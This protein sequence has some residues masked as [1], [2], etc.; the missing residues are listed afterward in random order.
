MPKAQWTIQYQII[1]KCFLSATKK[2]FLFIFLLIFLL[3]QRTEV[4]KLYKN[5]RSFYHH[6][7][8][9]CI[10]NS[11][12]HIWFWVQQ[13]SSESKVKQLWYPAPCLFLPCYWPDHDMW[14]RHELWL[15]VSQCS[16]RPNPLKRSL[17]GM[18]RFSGRFSGSITWVT[19]HDKCALTR[20]SF[21][22]F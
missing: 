1:I 7:T 21:H 22:M 14:I 11:Y 8:Y 13:N 6:N 20:S 10:T 15:D 2:V 16:K 9:I 17:V 3:I 19:S 18:S 4:T 5:E 12:V